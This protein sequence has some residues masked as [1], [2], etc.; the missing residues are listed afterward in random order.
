MEVIDIITLIKKTEPRQSLLPPNPPPTSDTGIKSTP[1]VT[2]GVSK[3]WTGVALFLPSPS[4]SASAADKE[5]NVTEEKAAQKAKA[6]C[7][8]WKKKIKI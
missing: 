8:A 7:C 4:S 3:T 5:A 1:N 6:H 2:E